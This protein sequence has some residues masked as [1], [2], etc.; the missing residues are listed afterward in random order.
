VAGTAKRPA[1][2]G[3]PAYPPDSVPAKHQRLERKHQRLQPQD[4]RVHQRQCIH[5]VKG[6][7]LQRASIFGN[8][9]VVIIGI[10]VG[11]AAA[12]GRHAV[13]PVLAQRLEKGDRRSRLG[14]LLWIDQP[15]TAAELAGRDGSRL[16][17][18]ATPRA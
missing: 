14:D 2:S 18:N 13:D 4:E 15:L 9:R 6:N 5:D 11:D 7:G 10:R 1:T 16:R 3:F 17:P 12:A 8:D